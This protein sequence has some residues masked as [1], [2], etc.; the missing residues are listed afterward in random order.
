MRIKPLLQ[1]IKTFIPGWR[2]S[3]G[4]G[5]TSSARYCY[6]VWLRHLAMAKRNRLDPYP[7]VIAEFGPGDS[8]GIGLAGLISG[9]EK[10]YAVDVVE[11]ARPESNLKIFDEIVALFRDRTPVPGDEEWPQVEPK[12][13][14]YEFPADLFDDRRLRQVLDDGRLREIRLSILNMGG[15]HSAIQ[16]KAPWYEEGVV[17]GE[18]VDMIYSQAVLEH[19]DDLKSAY[20]SMYLWLKPAGYMSHTIDFKCHET[21]DEWNGHWMFSDFMW[22]LIKGRRPYLLNREPHSTHLALMEAAG[23]KIVCDQAK[24]SE[25]KVGKNQL[26]RRFRSISNADLVTSETFIQGVKASHGAL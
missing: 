3:V 18:S 4:T 11:H 10:Y 14:N 24:T 9:C 22:K 13:D 16:Y 15:G 17:K 5:G 26:A 25:S 20:R 1:G 23:F 7:R 2:Y 8:L 6:S 12:L 21:A 19:V